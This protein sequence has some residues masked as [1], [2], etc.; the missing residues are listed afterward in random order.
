MGSSCAAAEDPA[1]SSFSGV[2]LVRIKL[3]HLSQRHNWALPLIQP[4]TQFNPW[5]FPLTTG[6]GWA[7]L[8]T[9]A[10]RGRNGGKTL[11]QARE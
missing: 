7:G 11:L 5:V 6:P 3:Q 2:C 10:F 9:G 4:E 8:L 1:Q